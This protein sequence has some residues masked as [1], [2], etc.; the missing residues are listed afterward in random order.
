MKKLFVGIFALVFLLG[1]A[2][3]AGAGVNDFTITNFDIVYELSRDNEGRSVLKTSEIITAV[4]PSYDQNHGIERA[5]P[6]TYDDRAVALTINSVTDET[7]AALNYETKQENDNRIL[8][9]SDADR[10]VHGQKIYVI[11]YSQRDVTKYFADTG[12]DEFY[13]DTNGVDWK[14][15]IN[16]LR[17]E[18]RL[19]DSL[20]DSYANSIVCYEGA[21]GSTNK[22]DVSQPE[23]GVF[24][25]E[26]KNLSS[27]ENVTLA[28]GFQKGTFAE[29]KRTLIELLKLWQRWM[30]VPSFIVGLLSIVWFVGRMISQTTRMKELGTIVPE[31]IPPADASVTTAAQISGH[32]SATMTAQLL[33]LAVRHYIKIYE[34]RQKTLFRPAEYEIEIIR[35]I[36]DLRW[37][38]Q[39]LLKDTFGQMP[40]VGQ[41]M[42][43]KDLRNN[44]KYYMRTLNNDRDLMKRIRGE[45]GL[46]YERSD[47]KKWF[48]RA[49]VIM[50][51]LAATTWSFVLAISGIM[52]FIFSRAA[53]APTDKGLAL[54][55]YVAGLKMY[56]KVAETDRLKMLQSPEG[57][58]KVASI[59]N[60][61]TDTKQLVKLYE[62]VLPYAVLLRE[63]KEWN[64]Q[65]GHYY[66]AN[67]QQ[68]DWYVG[69]AGSFNAAA[70]TA[71]MSSFSSSNS[72]VSSSSSSSGGS[73]GGGSS[74]GGGGGGGGGGW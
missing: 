32:K 63:E 30:L 60:D 29:Y 35:D 41:R 28:V 62:R 36:G 31:Y 58:E 14:T 33:D 37:E 27:G 46:Q 8:R 39:E 2:P 23:K 7:G 44:T 15:P 67:G 73:S 11:K 64:K 72:Y 21:A 52:A 25:V 57:A 66:E 53:W 68:P 56:I 43:L 10:Y 1:H 50:L 4:F 6:L 17:V 3:V 13:W 45:Y 12:K 48:T 49:S 34:T 71:A 19:D 42:N 54:K 20:I 26:S 61:T 22:C 65:L 70:F 5:I 47:T 38:E 51:I 59:V 18:L 40:A 16:R 69:S 24:V 9:I 55:R 74:G